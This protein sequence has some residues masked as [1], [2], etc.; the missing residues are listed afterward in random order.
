MCL[1]AL[2]SFVAPQ[3]A[4]AQGTI[5][6]IS[7]S[8]VQ[9]GGPAFTLLVNGVRFNSN[10]IVQW[11]GRE[12]PTTFVRADKLIAQIDRGLIE[13]VGTAVITVLVPGAG[14]SN[15]RTFAIISGP[16][17]QI[18]RL[19][20][21]SAKAGGK[22]FNLTVFGT[23]FTAESVVFWNG[24]GRHTTFFNNT[25]ID[26]SVYEGDIQ[27]PGIADICVVDRKTGLV[28]KSVPFEIES[29]LPPPALTSIAPTSV[30]AGGSAFKLI[31]KG[32]NFTR[33]TVVRWAGSNRPTTFID[34]STLAADIFES[35]IAAPGSVSIAVLE[36]ALG[37]GLS[38]SLTLTIETPIVWTTDLYFPHVVT[39]GGCSTSFTLMNLGAEPV[40]ASLHLKD[41]QGEPLEAALVKILVEGETKGSS[42]SVTLDAGVT[43]VLTLASVTPQDPLRLGWAHMQ[44]TA[45]VINATATYRVRAEGRLQSISAAGASR[46]TSF[47]SAPVSNDSDKGRSMGFAIANPS[48]EG[49]NLLVITVDEYGFFQDF[50]SPQQL[51]PLP[52]KSQALLF[53]H[54]I[55][56]DRAHHEG[57]VIVIDDLGRTFFAVTMMLEDGLVYVVPAA[58]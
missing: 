18:T 7:P 35:D 51:N 58:N 41:A 38:K 22:S 11:N 42:F 45:G 8:A 48:N 34:D 6:H 12:C 46:P 21:K 2:F 9:A 56:P 47:F 36:T 5:S 16:L 25:D 1:L 26:A 19:Q 39:G 29:S 53:L 54:E 20:P 23:G 24:Y 31:V 27:F 14:V 17:P 32:S 15:E 50:A 30:A 3:R 55:L 43:Q 4:A 33:T 49:I 37:G 40:T 44:A 28:T 52:P 13:R 10:S 57:S